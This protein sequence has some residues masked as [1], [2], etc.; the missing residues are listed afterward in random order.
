MAR[1]EAERMKE[2]KIMF[3]PISDL[4][5]IQSKQTVAFWRLVTTVL[6]LQERVSKLE[7]RLDTRKPE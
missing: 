6:E 7:A 1:H 3:K 4:S 5:D 2:V